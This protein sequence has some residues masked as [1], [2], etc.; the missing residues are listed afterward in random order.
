M[1]CHSLHPLKCLSR[2]MRCRPVSR[3][4]RDAWGVVFPASE[5]ADGAFGFREY[6]STRAV[7]E[8]GRSI[9]VAWRRPCD[10]HVPAFAA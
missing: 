7:D 3:Q 5:A 4:M 9:G 1:A 8:E 10:A 2:C 6:R